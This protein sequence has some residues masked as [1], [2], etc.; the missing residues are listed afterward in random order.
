MYLSI[1]FAAPTQTSSIVSHLVPIMYRAYPEPPKSCS[2]ASI[3]SLLHFLAIAYPSQSRYSEHLTS[4]PIAFVPSRAR[5]WLRDQARCL[6]QHN[7][8]RIEQL[9]NRRALMQ[10]L[11]TEAGDSS[12]DRH[13]EAPHNLPM[14]ALCTLL[15]TLRSKARD[16]TW[17]ILRS[18]YREL[19]C[20]KPTDEASLYTRKWLLQSLLL[21]NVAQSENSED[22]T[23]LVDTWIQQRVTVGDLRAKEGVEGRWIVCRV[24]T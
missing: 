24:K 17:A 14:E 21:S 7:F 10:T 12:S 5:A 8:A 19:S 11:A 3:A 18:V 9:T 23:A 15:D 16:T 6:R 13:A 1:L 2:L 22:G 20:P 4:L